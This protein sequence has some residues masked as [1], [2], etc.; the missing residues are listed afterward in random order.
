VIFLKVQGGEITIFIPYS[1]HSWNSKT[2]E[3]KDRPDDAAKASPIVATLVE[4]IGGAY[5]PELNTNT[6]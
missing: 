4:E 5:R 3:T 2:S 1:A 6:H